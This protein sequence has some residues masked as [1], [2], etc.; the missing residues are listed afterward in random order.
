MRSKLLMLGVSAATATALLVGAVPADAGGRPFSLALSGAQEFNASGAPI[1]PHGDNDR[2]SV[3]LTLNQGRGRVCWAFGPI[4][5]TAGDS[6]PSAAHIHRA[7]A[8]FA[9]PIVV[10]LFGTP[11]TVPA[12]A[13]YP[14]GRTCVSAPKALVKEIRKNPEAFY[15]NL[16]NTPHGGGVMRAQ[17]G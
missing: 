15:V 12:P 16:H 3:K 1:N 11:D 6:L 5:L 10:N 14:T 4:T 9:G 7:P 13:A 17:L 8:G 2:G